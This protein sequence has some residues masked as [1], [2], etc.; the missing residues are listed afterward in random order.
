VFDLY[1]NLLFEG[2]PWRPIIFFLFLSSSF[3]RFLFLNFLA[4]RHNYVFILL[5]YYYYLFN[6]KAWLW[7]S[8]LYG[9]GH[10]LVSRS[11]IGSRGSLHGCGGM[12]LRLRGCEHSKSF[13]IFLFFLNFS[14]HGY[15]YIF[16]IIFAK[17]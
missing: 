8:N 11:S 9:P 2:W 7:R 13:C 10:G 14:F 12:D 16:Y 17:N 1:Y 4:Q 3:F 15:N 6:Q 5:I